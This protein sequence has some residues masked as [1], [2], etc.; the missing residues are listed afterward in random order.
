M[1]FARKFRLLPIDRDEAFADEHA[2]DLDKNIKDILKRKMGDDEKA[3][4]YVQ[5]LQKYVTFPNVNMNNPPTEQSNS[6]ANEKEYHVK[7]VI[8]KSVPAKHKNT[9]EKI[10]DFLKEN[11]ISWTENKELKINDNVVIGS[12]VEKLV[13]FLLRDRN[14]APAAFHQFQE[15]LNNIN[16]PRKFIKNKYLKEQKTIYA[17][18]EHKIGKRKSPQK[19]S[20]PKLLSYQAGNGRQRDQLKN[21]LKNIYAK[22]KYKNVKQ[23]SANLACLSVPWLKM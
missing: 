12:D 3:K 5:I 1:E 6:K 2:S 15:H 20:L 10:L 16:F 8:L 4:L 9:A 22:P 13:N 21:E 18:P 11:K 7:N 19:I 17:R 23:K 14:Q